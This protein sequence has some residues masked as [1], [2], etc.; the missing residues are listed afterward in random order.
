MLV[1]T[2]IS[3]DMESVYCK[4]KTKKMGGPRARAAVVH[5]NLQARSTFPVPVCTVSPGLSV[6]KAGLAGATRL[7]R[8]SFML[9]IG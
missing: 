9:H 4:K 3:Q 1:Y 5:F 8:S 7:T 2:L 6:N